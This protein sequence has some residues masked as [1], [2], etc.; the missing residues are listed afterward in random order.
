MPWLCSLLLTGCFLTQ[1]PIPIPLNPPRWSRGDELI[2]RGVI[3]EAG[4]ELDN[5]FR[6]HSDLEVR[7]FVLE[8]DALGAD[9]VV[10]TTVRSRE[11]PR[12]RQAVKVVSGPVP[13][14]EAEVPAVHLEWLRLSPRG[15]IRLLRP[16]PGPLPLLID[17]TTAT[18]PVTGGT[19]DG[20][21]RL[22]LGML[23][24]RPG[25]D[26]CPGRTWDADGFVGQPPVSWKAV[27]ETVWNGGRCLE[28]QATQQS[29]GWEYP[30]TV[31][32][33]WQR[34]ETVVISATDGTTCSVRRRVEH[35]HGL[36]IVRWIEVSYERMPPYRHVGVRYTEARRDAE[37]AYCFNRWLDSPK[38]AGSAEE[39]RRILAKIDR[40][41]EENPTATMFRPAIDAARRRGVYLLSRPVEQ[42][43]R[44]GSQ[45]SDFLIAEGQPSPDFI[46]PAIAA[47]GPFRLANARGQPVVLI[48][49]KPG[50]PL[51][52][53]ALIIAEALHRRYSGKAV[54]LPLIVTTDAETAYAEWQQRKLS[55]PLFAGAFLRERYGIDSYPRFFLVDANGILRNR[56]EG[57]GNETGFLLR[58]ELEALLKSSESP[59]P[60]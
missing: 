57:V 35:R 34:R 40:Y 37:S 43:L 31:P 54:V 50:T 15:E 44:E 32:R 53:A 16:L 9:C 17:R 10:L 59:D 5:R 14:P 56:F 21:P 12:I 1:A 33:G 18:E 3:V 13:E 47:S 51:G 25:F 11:D 42:R 58:R 48:F 22:E 39:I 36:D 30:Q 19:L 45:A 46:A 38:L 23:V 2:Y 27:R 6:K 49:Y 24:P 55:V 41:L 26:L 20:P 60:D 8:A 29:D 28:L 7:L 52:A 4:E